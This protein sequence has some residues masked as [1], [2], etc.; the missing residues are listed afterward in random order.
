M[1]AK[2]AHIYNNQQKQVKITTRYNGARNFGFF[3]ML[4]S[5]STFDTRDSNKPKVIGEFYSPRI[6]L[7]FALN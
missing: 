3:N 2:C 6:Y 7:K 4:Q 5:F 1:H